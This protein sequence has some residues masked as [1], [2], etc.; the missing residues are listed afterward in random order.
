MI[1]NSCYSK[2]D[3]NISDGQMGGRKSKGC[4]NNISIVNGIIHQVVSKKD[5][6]PVLLQIYDYAQ[7][8]DSID[9]KQATYY[10]ILFNVK[11]TYRKCT[12]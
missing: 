5:K 7:I 4:R 1:Y 8:F 6:K 9:L 3:D 10:L 12:E 2:I 11:L